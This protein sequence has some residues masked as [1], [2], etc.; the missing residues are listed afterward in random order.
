MKISF[1][2]GIGTSITI[3]SKGVHLGVRNNTG[4]SSLNLLSFI[5][6]KNKEINKLN[7]K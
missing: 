2:I 6:N 7:S 4:Y 5:S 3:S 1:S